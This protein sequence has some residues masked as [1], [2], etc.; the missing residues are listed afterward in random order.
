MAMASHGL[1][2][3]KDVASRLAVSLRTFETMVS[4]GNAPPFARIGRLRKW[5]S[6]DVETW[7]DQRVARPNSEDEQKSN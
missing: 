6:E 7:I 2:S 4:E 1:M 3:A 5:R